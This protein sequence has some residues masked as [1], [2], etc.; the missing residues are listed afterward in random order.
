MSS[1]LGLIISLVFFTMF[2]LLSI[3]MISIQYHISDLDSKSTIIS[4]E[5]SRLYV[6]D[7]DSVKSLE[8]KYHVAILNISNMKPEFGDVV[9]FTLEKDYRPI[10]VS[11]EMMELK[12]QRSTV[13]GYY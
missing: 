2:F 1:K 3:D 7:N 5:I 4:Y 9:S 8:D 10:I 12:I 11:N 6:I 13:I